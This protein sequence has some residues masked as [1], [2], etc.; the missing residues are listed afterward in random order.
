[1]EKW[2]Y[3]I[4]MHDIEKRGRLSDASSSTPDHRGLWHLAADA[5]GYFTTEQAQSYHIPRRLLAYH[6]RM[7]R[8]ERIA[9]GLYR[10]RDFPSSPI[11][12]IRAGWLAVGA[13][14][15]VVSH[16]SALALYDVCD[17]IPSGVHVTVA[18]T[19]RWVRPPAGV[20]LHTT[21]QPIPPSDCSSLHGI[22]VT[23]PLRTILDAADAGT[24]PEQIVRAVLTA[25]AHGL[26][27]RAAVV[28][29]QKERGQRVARL[30]QVALDDAERAS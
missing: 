16:E 11:D 28:E 15:G 5:G 26:L 8:Y 12:D 25:L 6:A 10:L 17:V 2:Y 1:M 18:R 9:H 19:Q 29:R 20:I 23:A 13:G 30:L 7:G 22:Q 4:L 3:I 24:A 21:K 14:Q 27:T